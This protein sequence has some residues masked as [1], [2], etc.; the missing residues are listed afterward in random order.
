[1]DIISYA[2]TKI[3]PMSFRE[4][5]RGDG[6]SLLGHLCFFNSSFSNLKSPGDLC[7]AG[8]VTERFQLLLITKLCAVVE[9]AMDAVTPDE[10]KKI[11][12]EDWE[13]ILREFDGVEE[14]TWTILLP[15]SLIPLQHQNSMPM[16]GITTAEL[17][18]V[19]EP[20]IERIKSLVEDQVSAIRRKEHK[21]PKVSLRYNV[22]G[23]FVFLR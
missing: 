22:H 5:V 13:R 4:V 18:L 3:G 2:V 15:Y 23:H 11:M 9:D 10:M 19:F 8:L 7:G 12:I 1:M 14:R 20:V 6:K 21:D 16:L 17:K